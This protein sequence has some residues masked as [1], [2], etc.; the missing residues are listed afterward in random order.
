MSLPVEDFA[1]TVEALTHHAIKLKSDGLQIRPMPGAM[2]NLQRLH[3]AAGALAESAPTLLNNA[4]TAHSLEQELILAMV[5]CTAASADD[6]SLALRHHQNIMR[7]FRALIEANVSNPLY[8]PEICAAL[9][10]SNRTLQRCCHE[11]LGVSPSRYLWLRRMHMVRR[12]LASA[13]PAAGAVTA[14]ATQFG[15]WEL[16]RFSVAY[17]ALFG[18]APSVTLNRRP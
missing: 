11:Q 13:S 14:I 6:D 5:A 10:V 4:T 15:F 1:T 9:G 2:A 12:A 17:R 16:G 7:R 3:A 8:L 18:E